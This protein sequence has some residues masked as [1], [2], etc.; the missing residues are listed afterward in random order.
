LGEAPA[1]PA[2][3]G[4]LRPWMTR[5]DAARARPGDWGSKWSYAPAGKVT[6]TL[7]A[8]QPD[9]SD[10]PIELLSMML[11][12]P[13]VVSHLHAAWGAPQV[14]GYDGVTACWLAP[15]TKLKACYARSLEQATIDVTTYVTLADALAGDRRLDQ[16]AGH[17]GA[18][19]RDLIQTYP[20]FVENLDPDHRWIEVHVP[21]T[22]YAAEANPDRLVFY[23]D[24]NEV[25]DEVALRFGANDPTQ[26]PAMVAALRAAGA[27]AERDGLHATI[28]EDEPI[29]VVVVLSRAQDLR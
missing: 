3:F 21:A 29:D 14:R 9:E 17:I 28:L 20:L 7:H 27:A 1:I 11:E 16:V 5:G 6:V 19:R 2:V 8:G 15:T 4:K 13:D 12:H 23:L 25:V 10:N 22:E 24:R 26:R 18:S